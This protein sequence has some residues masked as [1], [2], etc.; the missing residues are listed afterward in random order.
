MN[1]TI[2]IYL[3]GIYFLIDMKFFYK[4]ENEKYGN[5]DDEYPE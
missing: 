3:D 1:F 5:Y 4:E 2:F